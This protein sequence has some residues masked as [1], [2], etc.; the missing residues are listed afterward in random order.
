[1]LQSLIDSLYNNGYNNIVMTSSE[2]IKCPNDLSLY[3]IEDPRSASFFALGL[4]KQAIKK[5]ALV[6]DEDFI[7]NLYSAL[8][9]CWFQRIPILIVSYNASIN[10]SIDYMDRCIDFKV[11]L[12]SHQS[13]DDAIEKCP[14]FRGPVIIRIFEIKSRQST[15]YTKILLL[16]KLLGYKKS[17]F[18][19]NSEKEFVIDNVHYLSNRYKFGSLSKYIAYCMVNEALLCI[20]GSYLRIDA[21][22]FNCRY[23]TRSFKVI[24][25]GD[26]R[27]LNISEWL[28]NNN[29]NL[30]EASENNIKTSCTALFNSEMATLLYVK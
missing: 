29:V 30:I 19:H 15:D 22:I 6:V 20:P 2:S 3:Q 8:T 24:V 17:I 7:S 21:N 27:D 12:L 25:L 5:I 1:M 9:E 23:I 16:L 14:E 11:N 4:Y 18:V 26:N 10:C 28:S 13:L